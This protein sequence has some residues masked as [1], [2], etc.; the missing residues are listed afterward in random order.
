[1][2]IMLF[3]CALLIGLS[4]AAGA[5][6]PS[7]P[8]VG[9]YA[10]GAR[11]VTSLNP[12]PFTAFPVWIWWLPSERGLIATEY[13]VAIPSNV[14]VMVSVKNPALQ[15]LI[16]CPPV[17]EDYACAVFSGCENDWVYT[18][19]LTCLLTAP[20]PGFIE[21]LPRT[22]ESVIWAAGC[23]EGYPM[24]AVTILNKFGINQGGVVAVESQSWGAIKSL[25][26]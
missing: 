6:L 16:G 22:G 21:V 1:M 24:E 18:H 10:D 12:A 8:Y 5:V 19:Q 11:G 15:V 23:E 2:K 13:R 26:R 3:A 9:L 4:A 17:G 25:Y 20:T 7:K 14:F